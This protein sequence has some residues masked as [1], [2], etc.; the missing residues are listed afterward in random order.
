[1]VSKLLLAV[2]DARMVASTASPA[3]RRRLQEHYEAIREGIGV[4]KPPTEYG[5]IPTDPYSH[6]P[7]FAGAQQPGMTGQV[8]EDILSRFAEMGACVDAGRLV[9]RVD[10][11]RAG[12]LREAAGRFEYLDVDGE[13]RGLE[14][15][16]GSLAFTTCQ[17]PVVVHRTGPA[18]IELTL[19][20]GSRRNVAGL[21]LDAETSAVLFER[22]G[23][24]RRVDV[25]FGIA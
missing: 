25:F 9:F 4:H 13:P 5:A 1:M 14:L 17:V 15:P 3:V 21:E 7:G 2:Q 12:E 10:L 19:S 8:K 18:H 23:R 24:I 16:E 6:T 11:F 22:T 20:D